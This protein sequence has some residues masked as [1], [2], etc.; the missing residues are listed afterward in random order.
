MVLNCSEPPVRR[1]HPLPDMSHPVDK[2]AVSR[3]REWVSDFFRSIVE[4]SEE[5]GCAVTDEEGIILTWNRGAENIL[6]CGEAD[7]LGK[8][9]A[10]LYSPD[11]TASVDPAG[12]LEEAKSRSMASSKSWWDRADGTRVLIRK[13][14]R[15]LCDASGKL[16]GYSVT[17]MDYSGFRQYQYRL[18]GFL[19][20]LTDIKYAIDVS[21]CLSVTDTDSI[22]MHVNEAF[23]RIS[24]YSRE[25]LAGQH[26]RIVN[27]GYHPTE[28]FQ[29][30]YDTITRGE[31]W[32]GE[33]CNRAKDGSL[34]WVDVTIV[35]FLDSAGKPYQ[36]VAIHKDITRRKEMEEALRASEEYLDSILN[37]IGDPV[38]VK[39]EKHHFVSVN[40]AF[41]HLT[42][43]GR[44]ELLGNSI[45]ELCGDKDV[46][47]PSLHRIWEADETLLQTGRELTMEL[48]LHSPEE[49]IVEIKKTRYV[50]KHGRRYVVGV[51]HDITELKKIQQTLK[52]ER[53][54]IRKLIDNSPAL[55]MSLSLD[56][57]VRFSN[58]AVTRTTGYTAQ[59][60]AGKNWF[61]LT[62]ADPQ[63][64]EELFEQLKKGDIQNY[65]RTLTAKNGEQRTVV[66][67]SI[68]QY[69][70][71]GNLVDIAGYGRDI[72]EQ[73]KAEQELRQLNEELERRVLVQTEE[74]RKANA[75]LRESNRDLS[76]ALEE[77]RNN[78]RLREIFVST[79]THDLRTPLAGEKRALEILSSLKSDLP[80][81]MATLVEHM[82][83][84]NEELLNMVNKLLEIYKLEAGRISLLRESVD[85]R[86]LVSR[87]VAEVSELAGRKSI[88]IENAVSG[89]CSLILADAFQLKRVFINL[90]GNAVENI[91]EGSVVRVECQA[92]DG[93]MEIRFSDN[94]P[95]I[96]PEVQAHL[97]DRYS[98]CK[99][100][101]LKVSSGLGLYICKMITELH[102]GTID[103]QSETGRGTTFVLRLP[104]RSDE[105]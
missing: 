75:R 84:T 59:E 74:L 89:E 82:A 38:Y 58:P 70:A 95:G 102:G 62:K 55:Y 37:T 17:F 11:A 46:L 65:E 103:V 66:W 19:R 94:G 52:A 5:Y 76:R 41:C 9:L 61:R 98:A 44:T 57:T 50:D 16:L 88:H 7:V 23:C 60:L 21:S 105:Q 13:T 31:V 27:S 20:E 2:Q 30:M 48:P 53:D 3:K 90:L 77:L 49:R 18:K 67:N 99:E 29:A 43:L 92:L 87:C 83:R 12:E 73:K 6:G 14:I 42:G 101:R 32:S 68:N 79:L 51:M 100:S 28:F 72:T 69:D 47:D 81:D 80:E 40:D 56:G 78:E 93:M 64:V 85:L 8:P 4:F 15:P 97:F 91:P 10:Q 34:F 35:P 1:G 96:P 45:M 71:E 54:Y 24:G 39:D 63:R 104:N 33:I 86:H 36:Y 22:I 25:E 26:H